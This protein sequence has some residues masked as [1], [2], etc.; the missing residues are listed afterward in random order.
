[1]Q[2]A[3]SRVTRGQHDRAARGHRGRPLL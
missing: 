2:H 3:Q 1:M